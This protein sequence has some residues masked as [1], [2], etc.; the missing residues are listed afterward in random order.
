MLYIRFVPCSALPHIKLRTSDFS[1]INENHHMVLLYLLVWMVKGQFFL[2]RH[3]RTT[4]YDPVV[5]QEKLVHATP[6]CG[7]VRIPRS[8]SS[9]H[10]LLHRYVTLLRVTLLRSHH[11]FVMTILHPLTLM[12]TLQYLLLIISNV[13]SVMLVTTP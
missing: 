5:E 11:L 3:V 2:K 10:R 9:G 13:K 7:V 12:R 8:P 1:I 6:H 4:K